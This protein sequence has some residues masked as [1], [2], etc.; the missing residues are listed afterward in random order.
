MGKAK[1]VLDTL[2]LMG[3]LWLALVWFFPMEDCYVAGRLYDVGSEKTPFVSVAIE[4]H[5]EC[6]FEWAGKDGH[7]ALQLPPD[8]RKFRLNVWGPDHGSYYSHMLTRT[9][10]LTNA[11]DIGVRRLP[12]ERFNGSE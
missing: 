7:F 6:G 12:K 10:R 1:L 9:G 2:A 3:T 4:G 5:P 11:G 8:V